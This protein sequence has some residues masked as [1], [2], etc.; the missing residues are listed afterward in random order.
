[1]WETGE[2]PEEWTFSTFIPLHK[3]S[4]LKLCANYTTI[5][6]VS[7]ASNILLYRKQLA[8]VEVAGTLSEVRQGCVIYPYMFNILAE[9]VIRETLDGFQG[10]LQTGDRMVTHLRYTDDFK[11]E[12]QKLVDCLDC[13]SHKY[14]LLITVYK[15]KVMNGERR[16]SMPHSHS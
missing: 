8:K 14:S 7:H 16:N 9:M 12:L 13:V 4:D 2:W 3:K 10:G 1:M 6:L 5:A 11:A 15:T